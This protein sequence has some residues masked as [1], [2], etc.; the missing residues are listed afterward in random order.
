MSSKIWRLSTTS[1]TWTILPAYTAPNNKVWGLTDPNGWS[2]RGYSLTTEYVIICI[3]LDHIYSES[4]SFLLY[5]SDRYRNVCYARSSTAD[6]WRH[7]H[8]TWNA[9]KRK[10][11]W[12]ESHILSWMHSFCHLDTRKLK[13]TKTV[14]VLT[15]QYGWY[16]SV[17][18]FHT[19]DRA[20]KPNTGRRT[21]TTRI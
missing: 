4:K 2:W 15:S 9:D 20:S 21:A 6:W 10:R 11:N 19:S 5:S 13:Q 8:E 3:V 16:V 1:G 17:D 7:R 12:K 18:R 14:L